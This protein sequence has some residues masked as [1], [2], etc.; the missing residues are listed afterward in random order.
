MG[1][2]KPL[3]ETSTRNGHPGNFSKISVHYV[4]GRTTIKGSEKTTSKDTVCDL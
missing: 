1:S 3:L 4:N 2:K